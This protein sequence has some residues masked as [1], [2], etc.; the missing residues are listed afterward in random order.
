MKIRSDQNDEPT[1]IKLIEQI[2]HGLLIELRPQDLICI[3]IDNWFSQRWLG[4]S[5]K[6]LG[7]LGVRYLKLTIPPFVPSRVIWQRRF[8]SPTYEEIE[9]GANIHIRVR[10]EV[11]MRRVFSEVLPETMVV[12]FSGNSNTANQGCMM[13]YSPGDDYSSAWYASW[14][15]EDD[16][17]LSLIKHKSKNT[18]SHYLRLGT[19]NM[20]KD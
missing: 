10:S 14:K 13:I 4:F 20:P 16:W 3:K 7:A 8:A 18:L 2:I 6:A 12:W 17:Q 15:K 11:A 9:G 19:A 5:G 1:F